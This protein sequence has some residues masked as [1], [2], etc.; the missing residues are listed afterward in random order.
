MGVGGRGGGGVD[1]P[2]TCQARGDPACG[3]ALSPHRCGP[4]LPSHSVRVTA[5]WPGSVASAS[6]R[7]TGDALAGAS[8]GLDRGL[9]SA[10]GGCLG[11]QGA[12]GVGGMG[13][14]CSRRDLPGPP[15][16][17]GS[18]CPEGRRG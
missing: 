4:L 13:A 12:G 9:E 6:C 1:K 18:A 16:Q 14:E 2:R 17:Q 11:E 7:L 3:E 10:G 15:A 5:T 8:R